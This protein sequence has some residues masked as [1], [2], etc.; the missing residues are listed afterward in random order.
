MTKVEL[1]SLFY[2]DVTLNERQQDIEFLKRR[3]GHE[4]N[5]N[6]SNEDG[7]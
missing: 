1:P 6:N 7:I 2:N 4:S 5:E 3:L